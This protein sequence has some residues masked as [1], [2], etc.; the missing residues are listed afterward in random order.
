[1]NAP[2]RAAETLGVRGFRPSSGIEDRTRCDV[3][4][5]LGA[6][7]AAGAPGDVRPRVREGGLLTAAA[8]VVV[9]AVVVVVG[10]RRARSMS[11]E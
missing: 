3:S 2:A 5:D 6:A 8:P 1:M 4:R 11:S 9:V 10:R 7:G